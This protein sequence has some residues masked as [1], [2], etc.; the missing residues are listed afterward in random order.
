MNWMQHR[1]LRILSTALMALGALSTSSGAKAEEW[2]L[3]I[4]LVAGYRQDNMRIE[5]TN[6]FGG[7]SVTE[8]S[9]TK[10]HYL[11]LSGRANIRQGFYYRGSIAVGWYYDGTFSASED[12]DDGAPGMF[13]LGLRPYALTGTVDGNMTFDVTGGVGYQFSLFKDRL[14]FAPLGGYSF[15]KN[16]VRTSETTFTE[17]DGGDTSIEGPSTGFDTDWLGPW[18]GFDANGWITPVWSMQVEFEYH[19]LN[20]DGAQRLVAPSFRE[21]RS[22]NGGGVAWGVGMRYRFGRYFTGEL[23]YRG[24]SW[25]AQTARSF[26]VKWE[27]TILTAGLIVQF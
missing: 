22:G 27:S 18:V 21:S 16:D 8:L 9:D 12:G 25:D 2:G 5:G 26:Q 17:I 23:K 3:E 24:R 1:A 13:P 11:E 20:I 4:G 19:W 7:T 10:I 6:S 15:H 14:Q